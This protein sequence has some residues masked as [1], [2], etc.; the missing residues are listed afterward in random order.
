MNK[1]LVLLL[2]SL[3]VFSC[4]SNTIYKEPDNL[5]P[6]DSMIVLLVDMQLAVGAR[7]GKNIDDKYGLNYMPLIYEKYK[8]DSTRF[9]ESSFYYSTNIDNYTKI[10]K[11]VKSRLQKLN[12]DN[13]LII[14]ELDSIKKAN[15][16][17]LKKRKFKGVKNDSII[18]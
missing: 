11:E 2:V 12:T 17:K 16:P 15:N 4:T 7:S 6:K 3:F 13:E 18:K 9:V 5:I 8:M 14:E 10:L 1:I